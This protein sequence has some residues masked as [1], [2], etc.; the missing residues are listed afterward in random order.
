MK[1]KKARQNG[2]PEV[3]NNESIV[4]GILNKAKESFINGVHISEIDVAEIQTVIERIF[5]VNDSDQHIYA[6]SVV[7]RV[8]DRFMDWLYAHCD[9]NGNYSEKVVRHGGY[10]KSERQLKRDFYDPERKGLWKQQDLFCQHRYIDDEGNEYY[11]FEG[12]NELTKFRIEDDIIKSVL[13]EEFVN[14]LTEEEQQVL[15]Y[16]LQ[17]KTLEECAK[18]TGLT[19]KQVRGRQDKIRQ[20]RQEF[21]VNFSKLHK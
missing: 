5:N 15:F 8:I 2:K 9:N 6:L 19:Y 10:I 21:C 20:K 13:E 7:E 4:K 11:D 18:L 16:R 3:V 17:D 12:K 14:T 1:I